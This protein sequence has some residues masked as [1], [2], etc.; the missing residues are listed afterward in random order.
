MIRSILGAVDFSEQSRLALRWA[1]AFAA[2]FDARVT[3]LTVVEPLLAEAARI[4]L[5]RD[6]AKVD[7]EPAL[8]EFVAATWPGGMPS[9]AQPT[10]QALV[11]D[12]AAVIL[13]AAA[14]QA[15]DLI[16]VGTQGLG[17]V[18]KW[19]LGSTT[20]RVLRRTRVSVL[21]V[22]LSE[23]ARGP[24]RPGGVEIRKILAANDFS[25]ASNAAVE[26]A[27]GLARAFSAALTF[28]HAV[29]PFVVPAQWHRLVGESDET[30][31]ADA[32]D[33]LNLL[34]EH[35]SDPHPRE[36]IVSLGRPADVIRSV[37]NDRGAQLIVMG[38]SSD[39]GPRAPRPGSIAY[40]VLSS[41]AVPVLVVPAS[42]NHR[43]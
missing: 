43:P 14:N 34:V 35:N 32:R 37:A 28:L 8:R 10:F 42:P 29:E 23:D 11:G 40:R 4:R 12:P 33:R 3:V 13:E 24:A 18:R 31:V 22:P 9:P 20:E 6:L 5:G 15:A 39:E 25:E 2:R 1:E 21:A 38:L 30:R 27:A 41:A 17:G 16:V 26:F 7:T 19:L 36:A